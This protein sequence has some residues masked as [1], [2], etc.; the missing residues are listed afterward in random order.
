MH[1]ATIKFLMKNDRLHS[2]TRD[3]FNV[4]NNTFYEAFRRDDQDKTENRLD[5]GRNESPSNVPPKPDIDT[6]R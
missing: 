3:I 4:F 2:I 6:S 5:S 1:K